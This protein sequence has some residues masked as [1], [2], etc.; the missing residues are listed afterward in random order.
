MHGSNKSVLLQANE[1]IV[2][3]DNEGFLS[4]CT[5]DIRWT[6][7]GE[8][9]L[10]GKEAVRQWMKSAYATPPRFTVDRLVAEDDMVVALGT[11][12]ADGDGGQPTELIYSDVWRFRDRKM[13]ELNAFVIQPIR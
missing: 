4:H 5:D 9:T 8:G 12:T 13:V 3:G 10:E 11:I 7:V 2:A 6:T 1:A